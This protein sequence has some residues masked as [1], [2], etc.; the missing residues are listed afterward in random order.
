MFSGLKHWNVWKEIS[1]AGDVSMEQLNISQSITNP[2]FLDR[3]PNEWVKVYGVRLFNYILTHPPLILLQIG[4]L[5]VL[6]FRGEIKHF[7]H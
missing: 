2:T 1:E 5:F 6:I 3:I 4:T 7:F